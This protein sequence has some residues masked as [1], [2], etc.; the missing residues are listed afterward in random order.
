[1][2]PFSGRRVPLPGCHFLSDQSIL[3]KIPIVTRREQIVRLLEEWFVREAHDLPW[4]R[5]YEPYVVWVSEV[6]AQQTRMDVV[7]PYWERFIERFP[8]VSDLAAA[9]EEEVLSVWSGLGYYRRARMLREGA[10]QVVERFGGELP[11]DVES[12]RSIRGI[13]RYTAGAISSIAFDLPAPVVDG[14]ILRVMARMNRLKAPLRSAKLTAKCWSEAERLVLSARSPRNLNQALM[15]LGARICRPR[16]PD[17]HRCPVGSI[18][19]ARQASEQEIFP[20]APPRRQSHAMVVPVFLIGDGSGSFLMFRSGERS[21]TRSLYLFPGGDA[22]ITAWCPRMTIRKVARVGSVRHTITHRRI[23]FEVWRAEAAGDA[24]AETAESD[25]R[26]VHPAELDAIPH[27]SWVRKVLA[28]P[29][30]T[31]A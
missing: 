9:S 29:E 24:V 20:L 18:C 2:V 23:R 31:D 10:I 21:L 6:M 15:E 14:N 16:S 12:L 5:G 13:G 4:R 17:C 19:E 30:A 22:E 25:S 1:M 8:S 3:D 7:V 28:L 26:W 27:P 11:R